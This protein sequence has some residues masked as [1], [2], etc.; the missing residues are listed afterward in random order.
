MNKI[1]V[2]SATI[3][4]GTA[5]LISGVFLLVSLGGTYTTVEKI[6]GAIWVFILSTIILM[7]IVIPTVKRI[8][9]K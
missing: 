1:S 5:L 8:I 6:G 2:I 9:L 4:L 7:P 3:Y